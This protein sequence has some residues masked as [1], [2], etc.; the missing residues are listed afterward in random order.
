[1]TEAKPGVGVPP[2]N[3]GGISSGINSVSPSVLNPVQ[4][5]QLLSLLSYSSKNKN[6]TDSLANIGLEILTLE[7]LC[8]RFSS[9]FSQKADSFKVNI[10]FQ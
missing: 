4:L 7:N 9:T 3:T 5:D 2:S 10:C 6:R 8:Q 1:M